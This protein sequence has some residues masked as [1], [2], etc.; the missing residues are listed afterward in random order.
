MLALFAEPVEAAFKPAFRFIPYLVFREGHSGSDDEDCLA[1]HQ[2]QKLID[3]RLSGTGGEVGHSISVLK[4]GNQGFLLTG[5]EGGESKILNQGTQRLK[6][7][8]I[9]WLRLDKG[10]HLFLFWFLLHRGEVIEELI[11]SR[12]VK[13]RILVEE[14]EIELLFWKVK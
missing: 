5:T 4:Q 3:Q 7:P 6:L 10:A 13:F 11:Q 9:S 14:V 12:G 1:G 2:G 8:A